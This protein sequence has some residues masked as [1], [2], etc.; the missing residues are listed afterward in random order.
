LEPDDTIG[1]AEPEELNIEIITALEEGANFYNKLLLSDEER[2]SH[3]HKY[4]YQRGV[5]KDTIRRFNI[6]YA[7]PYAE[8]EYQGRAL[9]DSFLPR[10]EKDYKAFQPFYKGCLVRLLNDR[11]V[12]GYGYYFQQIRFER[13]DEFSKCY[14]D[15]FA[16]R[17][18]FPIC[19]IDA[20]TNGIIGRRPDNRGLR[21]LR[22]K[23]RETPITTKSLLYGIDKACRYISQYKT[24]ILVEGIFDYFAFYNLL[25][26]MDKPIIVSTLGSNL[27]DEARDILKRLGAENFIVAYDC[28]AAGKRA[29][30]KIAEDVSG[31]TYYLGGMNEG[32]DPADKLKD[33]VNAISGFSIKHLMKSAK[34][35]EEKADKPIL[36]SHITTGK[37][38]ERELIFEPGSML[39]EKFIPELPGTKETAKEYFYDIE[40]FLPLLSYDHS[41]KAELNKKLYEITKLLEARQVKA[42]SE[43]FFTIPKNFLAEEAYDDLGPAIIL[44]LI[45][46]IEQQTRKRKIRETDRTIASWLK[47]SRATISSYKRKLKD[48]GY[49]NIDTSSKLQELSMK[50]FP[51][52]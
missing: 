11:S 23:T 52:Q 2:F 47:T 4:L 24:V 33:V 12:E 27:T 48:L 32:Q 39:D 16:G 26:D 6:G 34:R 21:W 13:K 46:V 19:N 49:L 20:Q 9:I 51:K 15:Y 29:I 37:L 38:T 36:I 22:Q 42:K 3:I 17:I 10:F 14:G 31:T 1:F 25:Q 45:I 30:N 5:N 41:N 40:D 28:D 18:I 50:Y 7:P 35:L 8:K 44:W 43:K